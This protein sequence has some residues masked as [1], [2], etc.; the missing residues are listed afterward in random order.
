MDCTEELFKKQNAALE[1]T[2][3]QRFLRDRRRRT[4]LTRKT[5]TH[6]A[7]SW[8]SPTLYYRPINPKSQHPKKQIAKPKNQ[9]NC[10]K[11][12][13][14]AHLTIFAR[15]LILLIVPLIDAAL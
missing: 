7:L 6:S 13:V 11:T 8:A 1:K 5:L 12:S 3:K 9:K 4:T 2:R 14:A 15:Y 10:A